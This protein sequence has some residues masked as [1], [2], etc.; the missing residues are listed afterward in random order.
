MD[1]QILVLKVINGVIKKFK[2]TGTYLILKSNLY[3]EIS[4]LKAIESS[5]EN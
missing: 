5:N 4:N 1:P 2:M 3:L